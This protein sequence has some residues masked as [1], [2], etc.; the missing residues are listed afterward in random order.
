MINHMFHSEAPHQ[1]R[2]FFTT[3]HGDRDRSRRQRQLDAGGAGT[4]SRTGDQHRFARLEFGPIVQSEPGRSVVDWYRCG[5]GRAE[6]LGRIGET[7][8]S[9]YH[10]ALREAATE[11]GDR[12]PYGEVIDPF[13]YGGYHPGGF[14]TWRKR[15]PGRDLID[16]SKRK[17]VRKR[18]PD[19]GGFDQYLA[20][21]RRWFVDLVK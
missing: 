12:G 4:P 3:N 20:W 6:M 10:V 14:S 18:Q 13:T 2:F 7:R 11:H 21:A 17:H 1:R 5:L 16:A 19:R 9:S 8:T 15:Q